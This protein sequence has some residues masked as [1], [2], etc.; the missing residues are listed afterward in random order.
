V[1]VAVITP[2]G[3][4][5]AGAADEVVAPGVLGELGILPGHIPILA[6]LRPGVVTVKE[7]GRRE[8]VAVGSGYL[9]V[10]AGDRV[11]VLVDRAET[12]KEIDP[13]EARRELDEAN[14]A[15]KQGNLSGSELAG[16]EAQLGW[17]RARL[18]ALL[19]KG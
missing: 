4:L 1:N 16:V 10:G 3:Q 6:A 7:G 9:Q 8:V 18:D 14:A 5:L 12:A 15:L 2:K 13:D 19:L 17:A 11:N